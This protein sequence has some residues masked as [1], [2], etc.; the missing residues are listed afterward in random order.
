MEFI[1][2]GSTLP[3]PLNIIPTSYGL[4]RLFKYV[5]KI[6]KQQSEIDQYEDLQMKTGVCF[7]DIM[8]F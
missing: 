8:L 4:Y 1:K 6:F 5:L 7:K 3:I 2:E